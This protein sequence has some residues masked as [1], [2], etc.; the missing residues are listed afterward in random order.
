MNIE[1]PPKFSNGWMQKFIKRHGFFKYN[2]HGESGSVNMQLL[3]SA[4]TSLQ[5]KIAM[6]SPCEVYNMDET[7]LF[8]SQAPSTTI[9]RKPIEGLKMDKRRITVALTANADGSH[10]LPL[11]FIGKAKSPRCFGKKTGASLGFQ[12]ANNAKAWMTSHTFLHWLDS[13]N[14]EILLKRG[15]HCCFFLTTPPHTRQ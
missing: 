11:F 14:R 4:L 7:G 9:S 1:N 10:K 5:I 2:S 6:F 8:Y 12:Y 15:K 13:F 3:N